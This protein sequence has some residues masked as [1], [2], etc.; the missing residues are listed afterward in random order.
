MIESSFK[1]IHQ[2]IDQ[3]T[4]LSSEHRG[5]LEE[6]I[7]NLEQEVTILSKT[8]PEESQSISGFAQVSAH[9]AVRDTKRPDLLNHSIEGLSASVIGLETEHPQVTALVNR[10][11]VLLH[12]MGI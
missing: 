3:A 11:C 12:N 9:E 8:R 5:E 7:K 4:E 1:K 6:L 10:L 2:Q